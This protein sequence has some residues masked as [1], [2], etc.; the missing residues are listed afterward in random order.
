MGPRRGD[1]VGDTYTD[2][3]VDCVDDGKA[4]VDR[5]G[6]FLER[7]DE[8]MPRASVG[9]VCSDR[10]EDG[11]QVGVVETGDGGCLVD[12]AVGLNGDVERELDR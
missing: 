12:R 5:G 11:D 8:G 2:G 3:T 4:T 7:P 9:R 1:A 6:V 10:V